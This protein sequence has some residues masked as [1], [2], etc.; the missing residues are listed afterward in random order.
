MPNR[1]IDP[2]KA[3]T[4]L[5]TI[6]L[7]V[8]YGISSVSELSVACPVSEILTEE[9]IA[10]KLVVTDVIVVLDSKVAMVLVVGCNS[11][12]AEITDG[13]ILKKYFICWCD[14]CILTF[15]A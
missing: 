11:V 2:T 10:N 14:I 13:S 15:I 7:M 8:S 3:N 6:I 1:I 4:E 5:T 9:G 12:I